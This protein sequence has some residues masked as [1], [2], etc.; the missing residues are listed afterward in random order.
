MALAVIPQDSRL[1]IR[2]QVGVDGEGKDITKTKTLGR[3]SSEVNDEDLY[4][5]AISLV[6]LQEHPAVAMF[7]VAQSEYKDA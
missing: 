1:Q 4:E 3:I 2:F 6:G 7:R 5:V